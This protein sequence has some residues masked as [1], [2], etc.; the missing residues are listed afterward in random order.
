MASAASTARADPAAD[1]RFKAIYTREWAWRVA[2]HLE[3]DEDHPGIDPFLPEVGK[4]QEEAR[5]VYWTEV[6]HQLDGVAPSALSAAAA[7][8]MAST[9]RR[10]RPWPPGSG[11]GITRSL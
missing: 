1:A 9:G 5:L 6:L 3:T 11:S 7:S 2:Q 4:A 8:T 10:S